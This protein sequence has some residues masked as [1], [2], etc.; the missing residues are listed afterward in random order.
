MN[1]RTIKASALTGLTALFAG[2]LLAPQ[3]VA[4]EGEAPP[5]TQIRVLANVHTD[6]VSTYFEESEFHLATF[7][8]IAEGN[9]IRLD[10]AET[11]FHV[12]DSSRTTV[13]MGFEF[14][15]EPGAEMWVAPEESPI[16]DGGYTQLWPGF[17]TEHVAAGVLRADETTF[18]LTGLEGPGDLELFSGGGTGGI[19]RLWSSDEDIDE[20]TV[21]RTHMHANWAFTA[22]GV[23]A[24]DV[25]ASAATVDGVPMSASATYSFVVGE[26]EAPA[27]TDTTLSASA[28]AITGGDRVVLDAKVTPGDLGGYVEF[29]DGDIVLGHDDVVDGAA[30]LETAGLRLGERHV[31]ARYVP[32]TTRAAEPSASNSVTISVHEE[33]AEL[34]FGI[35]GWKEGY[36]AG[37]DV[38]LSLRGATLGENE[39]VRWISTMSLDPDAQTYAVTG[40]TWGPTVI[41]TLWNGAHV[42]VQIQN[43]VT[44]EVVQESAWHEFRVT[45]ENVGFGQEVAIQGM[46]DAYYL[47]DPWTVTVDAVSLSEGQTIRFARRDLPYRSDYSFGAQWTVGVEGDTITLDTSWL[48]TSWMVAQAAEGVLQVIAADGTTVL[49]Q[50][51]PFAPHVRARAVV[52]DGM[53][54]VYRA[55]QTINA[56]VTIDPARDALAYQWGYGQSQWD[57]E[58]IEGATG[59]SLS[60][61]ATVDIDKKVLGVQITDAVTGLAVGYA[62]KTL[63]VVDAAASEQL[64]LID[65]LGAHGTHYHQGT[66][67]ELDALPDPIP[68]D[69]DSFRWEW[70]RADQDRWHVMAGATGIHHEVIAEQALHETRVR[71]VMLGA[72]GDERATSPEATILVDDH[73]AAAR[74]KVSVSGA[75]ESYDAGDDIVLDASVDPASVLTSYS[76]TVTPSEGDPW[77]AEN[78][79]AARLV[80]PATEDLDGST[81]T[82]SLVFDDGRTYVTSTPIVLAV[83]DGDPADP[84]QVVDPGDSGAPVGADGQPGNGGATDGDRLANT[85]GDVTA[86]LLATVLLLALGAGGILIARSRKGKA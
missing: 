9:G 17:S 80:L 40:E 49:G 26:L 35:G 45:G 4:A 83:A 28:N 59:S 52:L 71:V 62:S 46:Q 44:R 21:G 29:L 39:R 24:L 75:E 23:Y 12:G 38:S 18:T 67:I 56:S 48:D 57:F 64:V 76:W 68:A 77:T 20:F 15:G 81:V 5:S 27:R 60:I 41:S 54:S 14:I 73:G 65:G 61:P 85:G 79:G 8:D 82:A 7:A 11:V 84:G 50:S 47:G 1:R 22:P 42:K 70:K 32:T 3:A 30:T 72:D 51:A 36:V 2:V 6:A 34:P 19:N 86:V 53:Q 16:G 69:G 55:G 58:P 10:P 66:V 37:E 25:T 31:T 63:R 33:G 74:Q 78:E 43:S 13:P